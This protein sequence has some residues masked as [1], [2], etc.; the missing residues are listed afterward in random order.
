MVIQRGH[1]RDDQRPPSVPCQ[2]RDWLWQVN[3]GDAPLQHCAIHSYYCIVDCI[4]PTVCDTVTASST[5][6]GVVEV[7]TTG[8]GSAAIIVVL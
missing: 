4:V 6:C 7:Y 1:T 3:T 5:L 8:H 2:W